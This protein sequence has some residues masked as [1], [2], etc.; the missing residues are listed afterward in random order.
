MMD[1]QLKQKLD[2]LSTKHEADMQARK[3]E[4]AAAYEKD[5]SILQGN[6]QLAQNEA[7][8]LRSKLVE[9]QLQAEQLRAQVDAEVPPLIKNLPATCDVN[10]RSKQPVYISYWES[11]L[12]QLW[13]QLQQ[14]MHA[15]SILL[16]FTTLQYNAVRTCVLGHGQHEKALAT[17]VATHVCMKGV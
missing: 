17:L 7:E 3:L 15:H 16:C 12:D 9:E 11:T 6:V 13:P 8:T 10:F 4:H 14:E 5:V 1:K 2:K